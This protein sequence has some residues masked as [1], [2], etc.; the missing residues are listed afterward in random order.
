MRDNPIITYLGKHDRRAFWDT[1]LVGG[2]QANQLGKSGGIS[3]VG[4]IYLHT[5]CSSSALDT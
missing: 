5:G 2:R 1:G 3:G 4:Y